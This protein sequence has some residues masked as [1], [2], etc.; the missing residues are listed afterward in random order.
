MVY[1]AYSELL[2]KR[3]ATYEGGVLMQSET[4]PFLGPENLLLSIETEES[5][6]PDQQ[7]HQISR[8]KEERPLKSRKG[9]FKV[10]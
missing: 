10:R 8:Q 6:L 1:E 3:S 9:F 4:P 7:I 5:F 2:L